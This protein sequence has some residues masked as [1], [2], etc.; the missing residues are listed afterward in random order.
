MGYVAEGEVMLQILNLYGNCVCPGIA[1]SR[2]INPVLDKNNEIPTSIS[3]KIIFAG[4][5]ATW[6][7]AKYRG[8]TFFMMELLDENQ[9]RVSSGYILAD[10]FSNSWHKL[11]IE[12]TANRYARFYIDNNLIW[13]P[14]ER[15]H[16][17]MMSD[18]KVILGYTSDGDPNTL[19][20]VAY[21]NWIKATYMVGPEF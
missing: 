7:P 2:D 9:S 8:H 4:V 1:V 21:H 10:Q 13:A 12:V 18:R 3:M 16:P 20:G 6:F 17:E 15:L 14:F 11:K 5:N 19:A